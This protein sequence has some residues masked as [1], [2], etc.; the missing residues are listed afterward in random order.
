VTVSHTS[1]KAAKSLL[2]LA[3]TQQAMSQE[4][5]EIVKA[6]FDAY[7]GDHMEALRVLYDLAVVLRHLEGCR[8]GSGPS[9]RPEEVLREYE[10][11]RE[12]SETDEVVPIANFI[13]AGDRVVVRMMWPALGRGPGSRLEFTSVFTVRSG[14]ISGTEFFWDHAEALEAVGLSE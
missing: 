2:R 1:S 14:R 7:I 10:E 3:P 6:D 12:V 11:Q 9:L 5:V 4:N 13:D 8:P